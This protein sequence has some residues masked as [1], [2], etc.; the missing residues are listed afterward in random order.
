MKKFFLIAMLI[1]I[2][3]AGNVF[4]YPEVYLKEVTVNP[5]SAGIFMFP[6]LGQQNVLYGEYNLA[7]DWD[8]DGPMTY[9][10]ISGFCVEY[11]WAT[12]ANN[13]TFAL[14]EP[15]GNYLSAAWIFD[16]YLAGKVSAQ[17]AQIAIW[18]VVFDTGKSLTTGAFYATFTGG[19]VDEATA[20]LAS[21]FAAPINEYWIAR[22]PV[23]QENMGEGAQDYII[24]KPVPEPATMLLLGIGLLGLAGFGRKKLF[25]K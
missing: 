10:P 23:A 17:A 16:Q 25:K 15:T 5:G 1:L 19:Y 24:R 14:L 9:S 11:A 6:N 18:E 2:L 7:I 20:L 4:A 22:N 13:V 8:K 3:G 21:N 12:Q